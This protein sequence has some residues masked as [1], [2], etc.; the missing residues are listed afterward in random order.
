MDVSFP[1]NHKCN[2]I[3][4][5]KRIRLTYL[6]QLVRTQAI[7]IIGMMSTYGLSGMLLLSGLPSVIA[8]IQSYGRQILT[9]QRKM[10]PVG[11]SILPTVQ[12]LQTDVC[13]E[14]PALLLLS[15]ICLA[16]LSQVHV[17]TA[18]L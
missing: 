18:L 16:L 2:Q 9:E 12:A 11:L 8:C 14:T 10:A 6:S 3:K 4:N 15:C 13:R 1:Q 5:D 17:K 7:D